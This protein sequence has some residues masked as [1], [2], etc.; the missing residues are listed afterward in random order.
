MTAPSAPTLK[1]ID[2]GVRLTGRCGFVHIRVLRV[3]HGMTLVPHAAGPA[4][5]HRAGQRVPRLRRAPLQRHGARRAAQAPRA[6]RHKLGEPPA[7]FRGEAPRCLRG[8]TVHRCAPLTGR[9]LGTGAAHT[10]GRAP[11]AERAF[12]IAG[13]RRDG[14]DGLMPGLPAILPGWRSGSAPPELPSPVLPCHLIPGKW[15]G[16]VCSQLALCIPAGDHPPDGLLPGLQRAPDDGA[17]HLL[18]AGQGPRAPHAA[19]GAGPAA[20]GWVPGTEISLGAIRAE[21]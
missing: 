9:V 6:G 8:N 14:P 21:V 3:V 18:H 5:R 10:R 1:A 4:V 17:T 11:P 20:A 15:Y 16:T 12:E 7:A 13:G 2:L 19:A